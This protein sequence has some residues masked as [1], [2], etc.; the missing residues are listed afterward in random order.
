MKNGVKIVLNF[1]KTVL[2]SI[3][4]WLNYVKF[5]AVLTQIF[6]FYNEQ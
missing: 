3:K 5:D 6:F 1:I 4:A 2:N